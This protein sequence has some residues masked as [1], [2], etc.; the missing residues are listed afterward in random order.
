MPIWY[1]FS[2]KITHIQYVGWDER[3]FRDGFSGPDRGTESP[4]VAIMK[5]TGGTKGS[6]MA[7]MTR[8]MGTSGLVSVGVFPLQN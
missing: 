2:H 8:S 3:E 6:E 4:F 7:S 1:P 5:L